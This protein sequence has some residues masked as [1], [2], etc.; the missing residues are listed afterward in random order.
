MNAL[1]AF[2]PIENTIGGTVRSRKSYSP[3][4][5][6]SVSDIGASKGDFGLEAARSTPVAGRVGAPELPS[7]SGWLSGDTSD[8]S[9]FR[10]FGMERNT[11]ANWSLCGR[12]AG[13][14]KPPTP[15]FINLDNVL[16]VERQ[17]DL[18]AVVMVG[19]ETVYIDTMPETLIGTAPPPGPV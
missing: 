18:T 10:N 5:L 16:T 7:C 2:G 1:F 11:M 14:D 17:G 9:T 8:T 3:A 15:I 12:N 13:P 4:S 19:G 6:G